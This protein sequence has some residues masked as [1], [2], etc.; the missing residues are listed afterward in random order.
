MYLHFWL[1]VITQGLILDNWFVLIFGVIFWAL[2]Y[3][4]RVPKEEKM[5]IEEFG[6]GY[7]KYIKE[8]E[9]IFPRIL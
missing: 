9:R 5:M 7:T 6:D 2:L 3:F 1:L 8:T 4:I